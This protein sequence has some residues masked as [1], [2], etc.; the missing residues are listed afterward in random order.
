MIAC[1]HAWE[2]RKE[3][4][5]RI[6]ST[7]VPRL[8]DG[9]IL[10]PLQTGIETGKRRNNNEVGGEQEMKEQWKR[11][12]TGIAV[13]ILLVL[14]F[15]AGEVSVPRSTITQT[16]TMTATTV[17]TAQ[18]PSYL[19][20][21]LAIPVS[22]LQYLQ[23]FTYTDNIVRVGY[24]PGAINVWYLQGHDA[25]LVIITNCLFSN[26]TGRETALLINNQLLL[27]G[28]FVPTRTS[29]LYLYLIPYVG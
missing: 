9:S 7:I 20:P 16:T 19:I 8:I 25:I 6:S 5:G 11:R 26:S 24:T 10:F 4:C 14:A 27:S 1:H 12:I 15:Y 22:Q 17:S 2:K 29:V 13:A 3:H 18:N 28:P 23:N 21:F